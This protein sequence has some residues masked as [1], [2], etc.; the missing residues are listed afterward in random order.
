MCA[1]YTAQCGNDKNYLS[2][3]FNKNFVKATGLLKKLLKSG[4]HEIFFGETEFL[5][6]PNCAQCGKKFTVTQFFIVKSILISRIFFSFFFFGWKLGFL[7]EI[8]SFSRNLNKVFF[9]GC[10]LLQY[11]NKMRPRKKLL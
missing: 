11:S 4:F 9:P 3:F 5:I 10:I 7:H 8:T 1:P 2:H 6:F